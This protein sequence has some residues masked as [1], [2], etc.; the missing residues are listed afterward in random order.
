MQKFNL[1]FE[2]SGDCGKERNA[3]F[4]DVLNTLCLCLYGIGHMVKDQ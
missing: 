2:N 3:L 4:N 1:N